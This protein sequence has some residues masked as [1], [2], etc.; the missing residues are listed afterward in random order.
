MEEE[1]QNNGPIVNNEEPKQSNNENKKGL[2][3]AAMVLGIVSLVLFFY[4]YI[5]FP[6]AVLAIVFAVI[7]R[8]HGKNTMATAGLVTGIISIVVE[9]IMIFAITMLGLAIYNNASDIL[10]TNLNPT[11]YQNYDL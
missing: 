6:C 2:S 9:I 1:N 8:K 4:W 3:I 7:S 5:S 11:T 10:E